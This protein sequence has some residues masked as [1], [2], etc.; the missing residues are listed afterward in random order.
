MGNIMKM[1]TTLFAAL[2]FVAYA[3][4]GS[5]L[6]DAEIDAWFKLVD[7]NNDNTITSAELDTANKV[8]NAKCQLP[9][10]VDAKEFLAAGD[11]D[12]NGCLDEQ[13]P[14]MTSTPTASWSRGRP[15]P[16]C[17]SST[18]TRTHA[19][20]STRWR[21]ASSP[22]RASRTTVAWTTA[23]CMR[24]SSLTACIRSRMRSQGGGGGKEYFDY[25]NRT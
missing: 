8:F 18:P 25:N 5:E 19:S 20:A 23:R 13:E 16:T 22:P 12:G 9:R 6:T 24:P 11:K 17:S 14:T 21:P 1:Y 2:T 15:T 3:S 10:E 7:T 4:A